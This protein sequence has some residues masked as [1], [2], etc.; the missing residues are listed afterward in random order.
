MT[1]FNGT[2]DIT[3]VDAQTFVTQHLSKQDPYCIVTLGSSGLKR[4]M[5]GEH[6][7]KEKFQTK[8]HNGAG[9]HPIWNET[10]SLSLKNMKLDSHL[11]VKLYDKDVLKDDYLGVAKINLDE[12][13]FQDKKGVKYYPLFKKGT[14]GQSHPI[15]QVGVAA[16]FHCTEIPQGQA[17]L[18]SQ[19]KDT[20]V[21]KDQQLDGVPAAH[22][23]AQPA[24]TQGTATMQQPAVVV[25]TTVPV[26]QPLAPTGTI[27]P[28]VQSQNQ[29]QG[30]HYL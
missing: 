1:T 27:P 20:M 12:L 30:A 15:G 28:T 14:L 26:N 17:D 4:L 18:K 11:K 8:V 9:Q 23:T 21:R 6:L 2:I 3:I 29:I 25:P 13:L 24:Y 10:H 22:Q 16:N 19:M 7:G 5:E